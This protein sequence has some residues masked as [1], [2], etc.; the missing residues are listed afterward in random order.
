MT[1]FLSEASVLKWLE[2]P[3]VYNL[4]RDDLYELDP[5]SFE[6]LKNSASAKGVEAEHSEF[7]DYC[8]EEGILTQEKI[9]TRRPPLLKSP[10]PS[11]R[12]LEMQITNRCNLRCRHCYIAE[13]GG[14]EH[15]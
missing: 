2:T 4:K 3:S 14:S 11:L 13:G 6:F 7:V 15:A 8:V 10:E 5:E 1:Y 9:L 12:Y